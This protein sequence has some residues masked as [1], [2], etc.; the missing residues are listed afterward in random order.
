MFNQLLKY[1]RNIDVMF[2]SHGYCLQVCDLSQ[3]KYGNTAQKEKEI[4]T[5][6]C[7]S[8]KKNI[9]KLQPFC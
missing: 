7:P 1:K 8:L 4:F 3:S 5:M 2:L 9:I 6:F